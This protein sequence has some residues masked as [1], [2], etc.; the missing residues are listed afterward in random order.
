MRRE[1]PHILQSWLYHADLL[2]AIAAWM[3]PTPILAW[4]L[5]A[6]HLDMTHYR[7]LS[8]WTIWACARLPGK[9]DVVLVNSEA[10][11]LYHD[12]LGYHPSRWV[13][14]PN[15]IDTGQFR[16]D[17]VVSQYEAQYESLVSGPD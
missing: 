7:R 13:V 11:R 3:A 2:G 5:C 10:G 6:S 12:R 16:P 1:R 14:I 9:P 17:Q 8:A 4:N 15:G